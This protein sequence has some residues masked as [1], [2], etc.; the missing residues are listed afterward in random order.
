MCGINV[1]YHSGASLE[2][3]D[4]MN[5]ALEH[6]GPDAK[7]IYQSQ[8]A[9]LLL[10]S[11]RLK[12]IDLEHGNMPYISPCGRYAMVYNGEIYNYKELRQK[13]QTYSFQSQSDGEVLF[14]WLQKFGPKSLSH[15]NGMFSFA[16]WDE[17]E[18]CLT[19]G[20]DRLGIKP[21]FFHHSKDT[22]YLSSEINALKKIPELSQELNQQTLY[23]YLSL[24]SVPEPLSFYQN[25]ERFPKA[26]YAQFKQGQLCFDRYWDI[27]YTKKEQSEKEWKSEVRSTFLSAVEQRLVSDVPMGLLLSSGIDSN[28]LAKSIRDEFGLKLHCYSLGFSGGEDESQIAATSAKE[29]DLPFSSH[30]LKPEDLLEKVPDIIQHFG[31][32]F[33]GGMPIWFLCREIQKEITVGLTGTGGDE[34]FGNYGRPQHAYPFLGIKQALKTIAKKCVSTHKNFPSH[35]AFEYLFTHGA[36]LGHFYHEKVYPLKELKKQSLLK[37]FPQESTENFFE[38]ILWKKSQ[39][40]INDRIFELDLQTQLSEEFLYSQDILSMSHHMELRVPFLDHRMV[41]LMASM[42]VHLRS[43]SHDPKKWMREIFKP[44]IPEHVLNQPK[45]GF[46]I[47]YGAWLRNELKSSA[48]NL[49]HR[50]FLHDQNVFNPDPLLSLWKEH[51]QGQDHTYALWSILMFQIWFFQQHHLDLKWL[52]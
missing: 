6:R 45:K 50:D 52:K 8:Q 22:L 17:Q 1:I 13:L 41:E 26:H 34:L 3:I 23:H 31:E 43:S 24:L 32:P 7:G 21:L 18:Q 30:Q 46:M 20:R 29:L 49:L 47:P 44:Y 25:I 15:C 39:L 5:Q 2:W 37:K 16:L 48:E 38:K 11:Q 14:A 28:I 9:P 35:E 42:P 27:N 33:A 40:H 10:G 4:K 36:T 19:I 12:I 51:Q